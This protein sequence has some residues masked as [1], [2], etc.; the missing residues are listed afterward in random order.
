MT[1]F[2]TFSLRLICVFLL[3]LLAG[4]FEI[5]EEVNITAAGNGTFIFTMNMSRSEARLDALIHQD[6]SD[7]FRIPKRTEIERDILKAQSVLKKQ[8]GITNVTGSSDWD[9]Y[10]FQLKCDFQSIEHL[11]Q[12][13]EN[14]SAEFSSG[15]KRIPALH[16]NFSFIGG[17][18]ARNNHYNSKDASQLSVVGKTILDQANYTCIYRFQKPVVR[19][20]N[21]NA[22]I[23]N[24][25]RSVLLKH[26][27]LQLANGSKSLANTIY[28][29]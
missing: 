19:C 2:H 7:G 14:V 15:K 8:V 21:P 4:C 12:A 10:I 22:Q 16:D 25:N 5:L 20:T 11:D 29:K 27:M 23:S 17:A 6:S 3:T 1:F 13:V 18:F 26:N 9:H 24:D 28:L